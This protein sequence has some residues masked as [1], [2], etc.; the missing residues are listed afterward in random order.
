MINSRT[1]ATLVAVAVLTACSSAE[2]RA[3][4]YLARANT[5][6]AA[7]D[8]VKAELDAK[9]TLQIQPQ[10]AEAR[11]LLARIAETKLLTDQEMWRDMM[12]NLQ[13]VIEL[14]PNHIEARAKLAQLY[15]RF[16]PGAGDKEQLL[17]LIREQIDASLAIAPEDET[18]QALQPMLEYHE[19]T[20]AEDS[21]AA[22]AAMNRARAIFDAD[23]SN[24]LVTSFLAGVSANERP[25][26]A[27]GYL[28]RSL[29]ANPQP[30]LRVLKIGLLQSLKRH[31]DAEQEYLKLIDENPDNNEVRYGLVRFYVETEQRDKAE[32]LL[33]DIVVMA[34]EDVKAKIQLARY[35]AGSDKMDEAE[36]MLTAQIAADPDEYEYP[37]LLSQIYLQQDRAEDAEDQLRAIVD[38]AGTA[39]AGLKARNQLARMRFSDDRKAEAE[40]YIDAVLAI[41]A[42][43]AEALLMKSALQLERGETDSAVAGLRTVLRNDPTSERALTLMARAQIVAG[44]P[45]LA[46][47]SYQK[48]VASHPRN[49]EARR[50]LARLMVRDRQWE[51]VRNLLVR[52]I[53]IHPDDLQMTRML[54]DTLIRVGDWDTAQ[55]QASRIIEK[56]ETRALGQYLQGRIYQARGRLPESIEAFET[57]IELQPNAIEPLTNLVRSHVGLGQLDEAIEY[58]QGF[59]AGNDSHVHAQTLLAEVYAR[60][61]QWPEAIA[62]NDKALE[63]DSRWVPAYRNLIGLHLLR[64]EYDEAEEAANGALEVL[65]DNADLRLL[66]AG[67]YERQQRFDEAIEVYQREIERNPDLDVAINNYV[68]LVADHKNDEATLREALQLAQRFRN[69]DNPIFL[70]TLG[71]MLY[72]SGDYE[73]AVKVLEEAVAGA[74][75][76]PQLRYHLGMAYYS[77]DRLDVAKD[78]LQAAVQA[79]QPFVGIEEARQTLELL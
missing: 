40:E 7:G 45:Q 74:G 41:E 18:V 34:P 50:E 42:A 13:R 46:K 75:T 12:A 51:D 25:D 22:E 36:K 71:W 69:S 68:A 30:A 5:S 70:D 3:E 62:A 28:D 43:N 17:G 61:E 44:N 16:L 57:A 10:S 66:L 63:I 76:V 47:E 26:E 1:L 9:N 21:A 27:L 2:E 15:M 32:Q 11:Y 14:D 23:P 20:H 24:V 8:L 72:R 54:V 53:E 78:E 60:K 77:I 6:F 56:E 67:V 52:G 31:S 38:G 64:G 35:L 79:T 39:A 33:R 48:L 37:F 29:Q 4:K 49:A 19:A 58:L 65:P 73:G 59:I 55:V